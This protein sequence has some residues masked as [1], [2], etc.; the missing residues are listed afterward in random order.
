MN[1]SIHINRPLAL[2]LMLFIVLA[3]T[4]NLFAGNTK[5]TREPGSFN[6]LKA[7]GAY[8]I[9]L[10]Q[11][12]QQKIEMEGDPEILANISTEVKDGTLKIFRKDKGHHKGDVSITLYFSELNEIDCSGAVVL[13]SSAQ[14]KFKTIELNFSGATSADMDMLA[15]KV[16]LDISGTGKVNLNG[17]SKEGEYSISGTGKLDAASLALEKC[18]VEISGVG[19]ASVHA[20]SRLDVSISGTGNVQ[21]KGNPEIKKSI[22]GTGRLTSL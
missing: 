20:K 10:I 6:K 5:E 22:S 8:Q 1:N 7:S 19:N 2:I 18:E 13:R 21:Y 3:G 12:L 16:D 9:T 11:G 17:A 14:L 15:E 4:I